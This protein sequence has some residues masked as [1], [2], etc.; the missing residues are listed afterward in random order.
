VHTPREVARRAPRRRYARRRL[1]PLGPLAAALDAAV[2]DAR[3]VATGA[4]RVLSTERPAPLDRVVE[5]R[6]AQRR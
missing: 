4:L 3:A 5:A 2:A 6:E 1:D